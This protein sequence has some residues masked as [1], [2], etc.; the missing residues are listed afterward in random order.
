MLIYF[1]TPKGAKR[2]GLLLSA[3]EIDLQ[4]DPNR[5][6]DIGDIEN[7]STVFSDGCGLM[8][9]RFAMQVSKAKQ[10]VFRNQRYTP[11]VFQIR[12]VV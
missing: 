5:T 7:A 6:L 3:S 2:I 11:S 12:Y 1:S 4:L 9:K 10:I 8:S